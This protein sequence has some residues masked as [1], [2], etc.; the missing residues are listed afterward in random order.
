ML[1][2]ANVWCVLAR[3]GDRNGTAANRFQYN[4]ACTCVDPLP[5]ELFFLFCWVVGSIVQQL[6]QRKRPGV[7][8][9]LCFCVLC[10][11]IVFISNFIETLPGK[12]V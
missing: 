7:G 9:F 2:V 6:A 12:L 3:V 11:S 4:V 5:H 1:V 10:W 8:I